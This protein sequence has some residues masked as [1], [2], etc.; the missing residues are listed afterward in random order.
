MS[1]RVAIR[2][3]CL[4]DGTAAPPRRNAVL[5]VENGRVVG[6]DDGGTEVRADR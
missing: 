2:A 5:L 4:Y 3:G 1:G 6:I